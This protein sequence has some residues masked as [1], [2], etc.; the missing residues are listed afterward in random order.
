MII[1]AKKTLYVRIEEFNYDWLVHMQNRLNYKT[2]SG[3]MNDFIIEA[4]KKEDEIIDED[5]RKMNNS[6]PRYNGS[7]KEKLQA[8][9]GTGC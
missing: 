1:K 4:A 8:D 2:L 7:K 6:N 5:F 9:S 3:F